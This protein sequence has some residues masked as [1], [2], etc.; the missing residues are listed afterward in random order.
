MILE[1]TISEGYQLA[2]GLSGNS[3]FSDGTIKLQSPFFKSRG[4][5]LEKEIPELY[6]GTLNVDC[7][8]AKLELVTADYTFENINWSDQVNAETFSFLR[9]T[10]C[11]FDHE[12]QGFIYY[13]HPETKPSLNAHSYHCLEFIGPKIE[14]ITYGDKVSLKIADDSVRLID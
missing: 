1:G 2:S 5:D 14:N 9:A 12:Y 4:F 6:W 10:L 3:P 13:P 7:S 8:P 11:L